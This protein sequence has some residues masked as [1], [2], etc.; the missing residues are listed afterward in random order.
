MD[1]ETPN[2]S[3]QIAISRGEKLMKNMLLPE[4][5]PL[6]DNEVDPDKGLSFRARM[7]FHTLPVIC[8]M[9]TSRLLPVTNLGAAFNKSLKQKSALLRSANSA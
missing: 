6:Q 9:V 7:V 1:L 4:R 5:K 8:R 3:R 2:E